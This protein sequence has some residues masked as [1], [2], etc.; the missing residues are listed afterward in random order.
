MA[1]EKAQAVAAKEQRIRALES[2]LQALRAAES[3]TLRA[4]EDEQVEGDTVKLWMLQPAKEV[5]GGGV[6]EEIYGATPAVNMD[7]FACLC[8]FV[9]MHVVV[10]HGASRVRVL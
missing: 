1:T 5:N 3:D 4:D 2:E 6:Q 10:L 9:F 7:P 8:A